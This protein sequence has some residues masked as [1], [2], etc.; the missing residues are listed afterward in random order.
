M[1]TTLAS[2]GHRLSWRTQ[3]P[4]VR[5]LPVRGPANA[6]SSGKRIHDSPRRTAQGRLT[7]YSG[8][9]GG[10]ASTR[11][12]HLFAAAVLNKII[13]DS[14][15]AGDSCTHDTAISITSRLH[16]INRTQFCTQPRIQ[17]SEPAHSQAL[18]SHCPRVCKPRVPFVHTSFAGPSYSDAAS[19]RRVLDGV[20]PPSRLLCLQLV[21]SP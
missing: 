9:R 11:D 3:V 2:T 15:M 4:A 18:T 20:I 1:V 17:D 8:C 5:C 13:I 12:R 6:P 16:C 10:T 19:S 7:H 14:R 21:V